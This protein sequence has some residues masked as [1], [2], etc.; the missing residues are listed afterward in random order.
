MSFS[1]SIAIHR[2]ETAHRQRWGTSIIDGRIARRPLT[3]R[4]TLP[5]M[6]RMPQPYPVIIIIIIIVIIIISCGE[7]RHASAG[8]APRAR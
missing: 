4:P 2:S 5:Q 7:R 8:S 1:F 6:R 3:A